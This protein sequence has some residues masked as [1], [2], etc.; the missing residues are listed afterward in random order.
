MSWGTVCADNGA[1]IHPGALWA[2]SRGLSPVTIR[3]SLSLIDAHL[4]LRRSLLETLPF[5]LTH[6]VPRCGISG[7]RHLYR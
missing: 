5:T 6:K 3:F 7:R 2:P 1:S 4:E